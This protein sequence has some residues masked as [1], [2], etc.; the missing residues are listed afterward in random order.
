MI[1]QD[2]IV[3]ALDDIVTVDS[4]VSNKHGLYLKNKSA[5]ILLIK[6]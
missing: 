1:T 5:S 4:M 2:I 6:T 3:S